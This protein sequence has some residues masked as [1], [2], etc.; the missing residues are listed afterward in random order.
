MK[1]RLSELTRE[2]KLLMAINDVTT[3]VE[4]YYT[5]DIDQMYNVGFDSYNRRLE[6]QFAI[7]PNVTLVDR[8]VYNIFMLLGDVGGF[9]GLLL[10]LGA[11]LIGIIN[12]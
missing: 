8:E 11:I 2:D 10:S 3:Q 4:Q 9:S 7:D 6:M 12:F 5:L 1:I